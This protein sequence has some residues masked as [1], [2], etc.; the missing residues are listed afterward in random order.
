MTLNNG[1]KLVLMIDEIGEVFIE[2]ESISATSVKLGF[3]LPDGVS[4][5]REEIYNRI[6]YENKNTE[7]Q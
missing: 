5:E 3:T 6:K 4:V 2:I 1:Q 7:G